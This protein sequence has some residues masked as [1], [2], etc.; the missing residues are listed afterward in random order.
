M[1]TA[2]STPRFQGERRRARPG[3]REAGRAASPG[4]RGAQLGRGAATGAPPPNLRREPGG[5]GRPR[6]GLS[7]LR[8]PR[9]GTLLPGVLGRRFGRGTL[10][11]SPREVGDQAAS[12]ALPRNSSGG[13]L[14]LH[15]RPRGQESVPPG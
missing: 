4:P 2:E 8:P 10:Q 11:W 7:S 12:G 9:P 5:R 13:T 3:G 15:P 6:W 1:L 14:T